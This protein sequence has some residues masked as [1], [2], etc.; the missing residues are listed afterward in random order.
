MRQDHAALT[1]PPGEC[2]VSAEQVLL[3]FGCQSAKAITHV[4]IYVTLLRCGFSSHCSNILKCGMTITGDNPYRHNPYPP[5]WNPSGG[6]ED[7][8]HVRRLLNHEVK[9]PASIEK[10]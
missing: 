6:Q 8:D 4:I 10:Q 1:T 9:G 7:T 3:L 2:W 5:L